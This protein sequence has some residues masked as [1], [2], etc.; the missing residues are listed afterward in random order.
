MNKKISIREL[1]EE[2]A[3]PIHNAFAAQ[4]WKKPARQYSDYWR[5]SLDGKRVILVADVEGQ[6]AGYLT[7]V[8]RSEYP[9]FEQ[10]GIPEI[11]DFNVLIKF[12][13]M[14]IGTALMDEA[15]RRIAARSPIA[16]IGVC[17]HVDYGAAQVLYAKRGYVPDGRGAFYQGRFTKS[18]DPVLLNDDLSLQLT[19]RLKDG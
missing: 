14:K 18:G 17:L 6:F 9:P 16:G 1:R 5:E 8:W 2:D 7:I 4:G 3:L 10:A 12:R 13:R 15:E 19:K 11:V